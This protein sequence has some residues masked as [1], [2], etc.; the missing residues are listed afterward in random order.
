M[1][2]STL[3]YNL[4]KERIARFPAQKRDESRLLVYE[5][6]S[7]RI[8]HA[9]FKDLPEIIPHPYDFFRNDAAV[10][11]GRIFAKK[12][13]GANIECLLLTPYSTPGVWTC[14]LKPGKRLPVGSKFGVENLFEATVK[15]KFEDGRAVVEFHIPN[16]MSVIDVS[17]KIGVVPL[18]PYIERNQNSPDYDRDFDN[19]RYETVYADS[20]KRVAAAAPTAGLHFT[21]ELV[22]RLEERGNVFHN[23]TLHVGIGTFQP[24]KSDIVEQHKMHSEFYILPQGTAGGTKL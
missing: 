6:S 16:G 24:L 19:A 18:P 17:E 8:S 15:E 2:S 5:R 10:L 11:K 22:K 14:M 20:S 4:P 23:L 7:G 9:I 12:A 3:D 13:S 21:N 1:L